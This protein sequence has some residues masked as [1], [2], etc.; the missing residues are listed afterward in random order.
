MKSFAL[1][2]I[3]IAAIIV[4]VTITLSVLGFGGTYIW[5]KWGEAEKTARNAP[6]GEVKIWPPKTA[7]A[8]DGVTLS[9]STKWLDGQLLYKFEVAGY[10]PKI[11]AA[12]DKGGSDAVLGVRFIDLALVQRLP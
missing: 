1:G 5:E 11:A 10:P 3:R 6:L 7:E 8:L 2:I 12:R 9:L 4:L